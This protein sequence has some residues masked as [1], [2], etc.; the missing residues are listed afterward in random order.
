MAIGIVQHLPTSPLRP[1]YRAR[2]LPRRALLR[3]S[4]IGQVAAVSPGMGE[5]KLRVARAWRRRRGRDVLRSFA[6]RQLASPPCVRPCRP[7]PWRA[8]PQTEPCRLRASPLCRARWTRGKRARPRASRG[9]MEEWALTGVGRRIRATLVCAA[10]LKFSE[11]LECR[12]RRRPGR[13]V[14]QKCWWYLLPT[15]ESSL[16][17]GRTEKQ[18]RRPWAVAVLLFRVRGSRC[19]GRGGRT[20]SRSPSAAPP[21]RASRCRTLSWCASRP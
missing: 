12:G 6:D 18:R 2:R 11:I 16:G 7:P 15:S 1:I 10:R 3:L 8:W 9:R 13:L 17:K 21:P 20:A 5:F 14:V 4:A 19:V